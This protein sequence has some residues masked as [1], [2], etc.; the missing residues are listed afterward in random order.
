M[1]PAGKPLWQRVTALVSLSTGG[2]VTGFSFVPGAVADIATPTSMPIRLMALEK[3]VQPSASD[4]ALLRSAIVNV[5][6]YYLKMAEGKTPAEM[7]QIIWQ[8]DSLDGVDHGASCAAFA[9]LTL[10]L[11]AQ[12]VGQQSWVTG[13]TSYPW[14]LHQWADVRVDPNPSSLGV[15]SILQDAQANNRW[16][17]L[18]DGY[19]PMAGDWVLFDGHVEVVTN[20]VSGTL[21]TIGGD[22]G[23]NL[24]VNAHEYAGPLGA[25]GVAGFVNNGQLPAAASQ[26]S[27]SADPASAAPRPQAQAAQPQGPDA[28]QPGQA[29]QPQ[30]Q[31]GGGQAGRPQGQAGRPQGHK[32][33]PEGQLAQPQART[34]PGQAVIPGAT[35]TVPAQVPGSGV[36]AP[37][38][39]AQAPV[40]RAHAPGRRRHVA[41]P[42][43]HANIQAQAPGAQAKVPVS[44]AEVPGTL[45][46]V[47]GPAAE[48]GSRAQA[49]P[50]AQVPGPGTQAEL[51]GTGDSSPG[52]QI[53]V[54]GVQAV[55]PAAPASAPGTQDPPP[56][57]QPGAARPADPA[58]SGPARSAPRPGPG[59]AE[60]GMRRRPGLGRTHVLRRG[61]RPPGLVTAV[62]RS[63]ADVPGTGPSLPAAAPPI[64]TR[65][66]AAVPGLPAA[67]H[68]RHAEPR[69]AP[70]TAQS[71]SGQS[72]R[73]PSTAATGTQ[74][75]FIDSVVP[76][77]MAAQR[78]YGVPAAVTIAQAIE[79]SGWGQSGLAVRDHNLF[80]IKGQGPAGSDMLPTQEFENGQMV[81]RTAIFRVYHDFAESIDDHG[82]LLAT[83][84]YYRHAMAERLDPNRFAASLTGVYATDPAYGDKLIGI[85]QQYDLYRYDAG[86]HATAPGVT[87]SAASAGGASIPGLPPRPDPAPSIVPP[88]PVRS[89]HPLHHR[90]RA[91]HDHR[92]RPFRTPPAAP[93]R[94]DESPPAPTQSPPVQSQSPPVQSQ[95]PPAQ[96]PPVRPAPAATPQPVQPT[97]AP[98]PVR[99][100]PA[101]EPAPSRPAAPAPGRSSAPSRPRSKQPPPIQLVS[102]IRVPAAAGR[103]AAGRPAVGR[104]VAGSP[105]RRAGF[106]L[107]H[108]RHHLPLSVRNAFQAT[109]R[110]PIRHAESLYRDVA[111]HSG[112]RWELLAA[113]DWMQCEARPRYSPVHGEK[114][115]T[116]NP[117]GTIYHTKSESLEQVA[118]D[119]I[120]LSGAVYQIDLTS[121]ALLSVRDLANVFAAFRWG[122][123]LRLHRTS[124]M[125]F[126]YSVAGLTDHHTNMRWPSI[127]EPNAPDRPGARFHRPFGA[128]PVVLGL[129]YPAVD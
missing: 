23:P 119:L 76:G 98:Q 70:A 128:V 43:S 74:Q 12:V 36:Q 73:A 72:L 77:A 38:P 125:E 116:L 42:R 32:A 4:D 44:Q 124:A 75:S 31:A 6:S 7:E 20:Y 86:H 92:V 103:P 129:N 15:T 46:Q 53:P 85:M 112:I 19:L 123:L 55:D 107:R 117:D 47:A 88:Q 37:G 17:P 109:A 8:Q 84:G 61:W 78:K 30:G 54:P 102:D 126:P 114:L 115:G 28:R 39:Q 93:F 82:K 79:E 48:A 122:G 40:P 64:A 67:A 33:T 118:D 91:H 100:T 68:H 52:A 71:R 110:G 50:Q 97:P 59:R 120:D 10:E 66:S 99:P 87:G 51:P 69:S 49:G 26:S 81:N 14:P 21:Y 41:D 111:S 83:S 104:P 121:P 105:S 95:S 2:A 45:P 89:G 90:R 22:S 65:G 16:H 63:G 108:Y 29:G 18:G 106:P 56:A 24:S 35:P 80:G 11:G 13:G 127:D 94:P 25:Q 62:P 27:Q 9:S 58:T 60:P 57:G 5:A 96:S 1:N 113:C 101:P 3:S 34:A